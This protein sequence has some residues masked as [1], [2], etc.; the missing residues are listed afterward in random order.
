[1]TWVASVQLGQMYCWT[2][3]SPVY[4]SMPMQS[5]WNQSSQR[6]QAIMKRWLSGPRQMQYGPLS[7]S[8]SS[9]PPS[10]ESSSA[11]A[12]P[13]TDAPSA[14]EDF[15]A[16]ALPFLP[17]PAPLP[18]RLG[19]LTGLAVPFFLPL[20]AAGFEG[21]GGG[22]AALLLLRVVGAISSSRF[23]S[24]PN[25]EMLPFLAGEDEVCDVWR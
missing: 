25:W 18:P 13:A 19:A 17:P 16:A 5:P 9:S 8:S 20:G 14:P 22:L 21:G 23:P 3:F 24:R 7:D 15:L 2:R 12:L 1:V 11:A 10:S 4:L 6:S